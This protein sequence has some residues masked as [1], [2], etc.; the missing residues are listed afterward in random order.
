MKA[1]SRGKKK[2]TGPLFHDRT[3]KTAAVASSVPKEIKKK[4]KK[5]TK[6]R[7]NSIPHVII[8]KEA[9]K[10]IIKKKKV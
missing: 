9:N 2:E 8:E 5:K 4:K 7:K 1:P 10:Q 6:V 3:Y